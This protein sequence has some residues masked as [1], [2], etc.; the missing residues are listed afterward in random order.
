MTTIAK[1]LFV[2]IL[3]LLQAGANLRFKISSFSTVT[4]L[5]VKGKQGMNY[6]VN[7]RVFILYN[8]HDQVIFYV[9]VP[10]N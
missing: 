2:R 7:D 5:R 1:T 9:A 3:Q 6:T 8:K 10:C 4:P